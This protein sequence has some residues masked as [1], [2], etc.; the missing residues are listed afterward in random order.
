[1]SK[2]KP[3]GLKVRVKVYLHPPHPKGTTAISAA[4]AEYGVVATVSSAGKG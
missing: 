4:A 2:N 1:M 3:S